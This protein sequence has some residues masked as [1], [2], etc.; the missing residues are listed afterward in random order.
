M[1]TLHVDT[2]TLPNGK[3]ARREVIDHPGAVAVVPLHADGTVTL[4]DQYRHAVGRVTREIPAG[5]LD[6]GESP[7]ACAKRELAEE[8]GLRAKR[9]Q[10]LASLWT[11][12]GFTDEVIHL[13]LATGLSD[14]GSQPDEDEFV[15]VHRTSFQQALVDLRSGKI[16]DAKSTAGLLLTADHLPRRKANL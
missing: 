5:K 9:W 10:R 6:K 14:L 12:P 11:T 8:T 16:A 7:L 15:R 3:K 2:V 4:V 1:L 13:F